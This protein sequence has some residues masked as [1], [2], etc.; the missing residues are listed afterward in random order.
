MV[1]LRID[2]ACTTSG[3]YS[4]CG[5]WAYIINSEIAKI[6]S[7]GGEFNTTNNRMEIEAIIQGLKKIYEIHKFLLD[8]NKLDIKVITDSE[9]IVKTLEGKYKINVNKDKW[10]ELMK[11]ISRLEENEF[12]LEFIWEKGKTSKESKE[13]DKMA[14]KARDSQK[15]L[16][17]LERMKSESLTD[18]ST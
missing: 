18:K 2:G 11:L 9:L 16:L 6:D 7:C 10:A 13:V 3:K 5:G 1:L 17:E 4:G 12:K 8:Y 14:R 15:N